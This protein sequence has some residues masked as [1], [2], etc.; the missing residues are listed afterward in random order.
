MKN[1]VAVIHKE[2]DSDYGV[3]FPDFPGCVTAGSTLEEVK[4]MAFEAL[5]FH[6]QG[7][8]EDGANIPDPSVLDDIVNDPEN[9]DA[10]TFIV[11]PSRDLEP[12]AVRVNITIQKTI[13]DQI[14]AFTKS[15][16][17]S[18]SA[19]LAQAALKELANV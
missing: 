10:L 5:S 19:F 15:C 18:R 9:A 12:R 1:F 17:M 13:L 11:V 3:S 6:I 7:M 8:I 16:G 4:N 14:D 2:D